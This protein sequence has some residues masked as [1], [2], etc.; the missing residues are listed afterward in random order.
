MAGNYQNELSSNLMRMKFMQRNNKRSD[1]AEDTNNTLNTSQNYGA[2]QISKNIVMIPSY[3]PCKPLFELGRMSFRNFNPE[4]EK[5]Y[6]EQYTI[7]EQ[8]LAK[9]SE[10]TTTTTT[11][12]DL[13]AEKDISDEE[14]AR[15]Y[16][17]L[18]DSIGKKLKKKRSS[19]HMNQAS[20]M[21][22]STSFQPFKKKK[23][24]LKPNV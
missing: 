18:V 24:F 17:T 9:N 20:P 21:Q 23:K 8:S 22:S 13:S 16:N 3:V 5:L 10:N 15:R 6:N 12:T 2:F 7:Y 4:I 11:E 14:L 19:S 1:I